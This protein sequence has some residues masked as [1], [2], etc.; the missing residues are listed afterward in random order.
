MDSPSGSPNRSR[1]G[2]ESD[3]GFGRFN[4]FGTLRG[5]GAVM[6]EVPL[7]P[8]RFGEDNLPSN[9]GNR[10]GFALPYVTPTHLAPATIRRDPGYAVQPSAPPL[11]P[12][13]DVEGEYIGG[14]VDEYPGTQ[15]MY[16]E[17]SSEGDQGRKFNPDWFEFGSPREIF[18]ENWRQPVAELIGTALLVFLCTGTLQGK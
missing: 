7:T 18:Y 14:Y 4:T 16:A 12:D 1:S 9:I 6:N 13:P 8:L 3:D 5:D 15:Q 2:S 17:S 11:Y 10:K